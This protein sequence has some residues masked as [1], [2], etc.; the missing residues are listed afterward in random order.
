MTIPGYDFYRDQVPGLVRTTGGLGGDIPQQTIKGHSVLFHKRLYKSPRE[1]A[2][3]LDKTLRGGYGVL[4]IGTVLATDQNDT[5]KLVPYTPDTIAYT[6]VSRVFLLNDCSNADN[7]YVDLMESY[8]L[9]VG[10][11]IVMSN[12]D[13]DYEDEEIESIDRTTYASLGK[14]LVT[15]VGTAAADYTVA[16]KGNCYVKAEDDTSGNKNSKATYILEME[17]D[18]G[19]GEDAEGGLGTVLLS[20]A[21]IYQSDCPNMDTQAITDLGNVSSDGIYYIIK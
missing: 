4:E 11:T 15:V 5:D 3:L 19:A 2:L 8:K 14:A 10:D 20:N 6:D 16:K 13:D 17:V 7:F 1:V 9:A 21:I 18:T 12:T